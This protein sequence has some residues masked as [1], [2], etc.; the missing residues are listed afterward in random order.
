VRDGFCFTDFG[1]GCWFFPI[2]RLAR[3]ATI[4]DLL[5]LVMFYKG[6]RF[7]TEDVNLVRPYFKDFCQTNLWALPASIA[8]V[9]IDGDIPVARAIL[10][11]IIGY[12]VFSMVED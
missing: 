3:S 2:A 11:P 12:H 10:K 9:R 1:T 4:P 7:F 6:H 8:F 5:A